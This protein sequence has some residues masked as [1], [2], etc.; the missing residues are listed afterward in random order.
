MRILATRAFR[1]VL[2]AAFFA[3]LSPYVALA[4]KTIQPRTM[5]KIGEV[6]PRFVSYNVEAVEVTGGRFWKPYKNESGQKNA[7]AGESPQA[8]NQLGGAGADLYEYRPPINLF[9]P[10]LRKLAASL[11]PSYLRVSGTWQNS[12]YFQDD[13]NP[14]MAAAPEGYKGVL[15]RAEWKGVVDFSRAVGAELV[16]SVAVSAG[17]RDAG[18][19]WKPDQA[20]ALFNYTK[21]A[22]G[23]VAATEFMNEPTFATM[24][25][26]PSGYDASEFARDVKEFRSF[27][28][29][30]S[31]ETIFLG[32]GSIGEGVPLVEGMPMPKLISSEDM[33]KGTGPVFDA[34]SYHFYTTLSQRCVGNAGL[35]WEKVLTPAYLDRNPEAEEFYSKLRDAY[36]PGKAIWLTETG[37]AGCGGNR[38][39]SD[40]VD[41]FRLVDQLGALAQK[42]VQT[43][44]INTL[45][46]SDYG[47]LDPGSLDPR[48]DYWAALLWNRTMG[49]RVLDPGYSTSASTRLYAQCAKEGKGSVALVVLNL[50]R[51][52]EQTLQIPIAGERYTLSAPDLLSKVVSLNGAELKADADGTLPR[53]AGAPFNA[54]AVRFAPATITY[55]VL[56]DARNASCKSK[57][58]KQDDAE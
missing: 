19:A 53:I 33:L 36:L 51:E 43:V 32:P 28:R 15:T 16:T 47:L 2:L 17:T 13:D 27:L 12:T 26:A 9:N 41:S 34:F 7:S 8:L 52:A 37:E 39:A 55:I 50:D 46:S 4:Q 24:G 25:G 1:A 58:T 20:K 56:P 42:G 3:T 10:R 35:S 30:E 40:F 21:K 6:G 38:W 23:H 57:A 45:A 49:S 11:G 29:A 18:G 44:I 5:A 54:G 31:P 22:G 48:P 14:A